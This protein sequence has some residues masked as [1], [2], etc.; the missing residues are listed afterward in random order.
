MVLGPSWR[1]DPW[2][3]V[4]DHEKPENWDRPILLVIPENIENSDEPMHAIL[5]NWLKD[6]LS[7]RRNTIRFLL[8][9]NSLFSDNELIFLSRCSFLCSKKAWGQE[10]SYNSLHHEY[11]TKLERI[12]KSSFDRFAVL[13]KWD[14]QNPTG[15]RFETQKISAQGKDIP[16]AVEDNIL[17][18]LFDFDEFKKNV[19][20]C[21]EKSFFIKDIINSFIE[22]PPLPSDSVVPYLKEDKI[23]DMIFQIAASGDIVINAKGAWI[24]R[25]SDDV[26]DEGALNVIRSRANDQMNVMKGYQLSLPGATGGAPVGVAV[27]ADVPSLFPGFDANGSSVADAADGMRQP[28]NQNVISQGGSTQPFSLSLDDLQSSPPVRVKIPRTKSSAPRS[29]INLIG[30]LELWDLS[31]DVTINKATLEFD[32]LSVSQIK[33][34]LQRIP[35]AYQAGLSIS[36][37]D[38][39]S[40]GKVGSIAGDSDE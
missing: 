12:L 3:E 36:Y 18:N 1:T 24:G 4:K 29:G 22:P 9:K 30:Q 16:K 33:Q 8:T 27:Q 17:Q 6:K 11:Q 14:Y 25:R 23:V 19:L 40:D 21:A 15:C 37:D 5:G 13:Y 26:S 35:T 38:I 20:Y 34:I 28:D 39:E 32:G 7:S 2:S 31:S 10:R